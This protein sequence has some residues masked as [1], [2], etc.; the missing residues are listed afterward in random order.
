MRVRELNWNADN[1]DYLTGRFSG[2]PKLWRS[3]LWSLENMAEFSITRHISTHHKIDPTFSMLQN[4]TIKRYEK[5]KILLYIITLVPPFTVPPF[6]LCLHIPCIVP[7]LQKWSLHYNRFKVF[8]HLPC[9][10][11]YRAHNFRSPENPGKWGHSC[12]I[13]II[14]LVWLLYPFL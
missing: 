4:V 6:T 11:I 14:I 1:I 9:T 7:F 8:F 12:I 10:S 3:K 2:G 13:I 5:L